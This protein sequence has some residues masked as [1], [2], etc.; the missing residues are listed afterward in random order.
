M[1]EGGRWQWRWQQ[2][3]KGNGDRNGNSDRNGNVE[4]NSDGNGKG[5]SKGNSNS[6]RDGNGDGNGNGNGNGNG[7][8]RTNISYVHVAHD[9]TNISYVCACEPYKF[10]KL[11]NWSGLHGIEQEMPRWQLIV[12]CH[13]ML[14]QQT[15]L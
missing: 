6:N 2:H 1:C 12:G 11:S 10:D 13:I 15:S 9:P 4:G 5:N 3:G 7:D 8:G 14:K